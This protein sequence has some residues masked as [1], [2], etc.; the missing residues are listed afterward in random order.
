MR[1]GWVVVLLVAVAAISAWYKQRA[2]EPAA[3]GPAAAPS[4]SEK[5]PKPAV[6]QPGDPRDAPRER[7]ERDRTDRPGSGRLS[8][9]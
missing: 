9:K 3:A 1:V 8:S 2:S 6:R 7:P 4:S 5:T